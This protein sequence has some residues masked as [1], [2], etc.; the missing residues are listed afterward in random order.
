MIILHLHKK[1]ETLTNKKCTYIYV[2]HK[3][4]A[5]DRRKKEKSYKLFVF[6]ITN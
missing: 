1:V 6:R 3:L 5:M 4:S 2:K